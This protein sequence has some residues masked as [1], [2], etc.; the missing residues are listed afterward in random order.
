MHRV[1]QRVGG[2]LHAHARLLPP[3]PIDE[4]TLATQQLRV[5]RARLDLAERALT[6]ERRDVLDLESTLRAAAAAR[7]AATAATV[8]SSPMHQLQGNATVDTVAMTL[9]AS[10]QAMDDEIVMDD[11]GR[12]ARLQAQLVALKI[13][14]HGDR[15]RVAEGIASTK[16]LEQWALA[17]ALVDPDDLYTDSGFHEGE[18]QRVLTWAQGQDENRASVDLF[19]AQLAQLALDK[20]RN[21]SREL[22]ATLQRTESASSE[23]ARKFTTYANYACPIVHEHAEMKRELG[24]VREEVRMLRAS[25]MA[26][27]QARLAVPV[28]ALGISAA[29]ECQ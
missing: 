28:L 12:A 29:P 4:E 10:H 1:Q 6:R 24:K 27:E 20:V 22:R 5:A 13:E 26:T 9:D 15:L 25:L 21:E 17:L 2:P 3:P 7:V 19:V 11:D 14:N 16:D 18:W 23:V 8:A